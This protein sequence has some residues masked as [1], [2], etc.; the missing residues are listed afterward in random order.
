V[1]L[2]KG[3]VAALLDRQAPRRSDRVIVGEKTP[4][5][6]VVGGPLTNS[7]SV[8][9]R[10]RHLLL[11]YHLEGVGGLYELVNQDRSH[12]PEFTVYRGDKK[13]AT[14]RFQYG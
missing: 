3:D 5:V 10:G 11:S 2:Q 4:G 6:L 8:M 13:L 1:R 14:G 12:P 9:K 7:L